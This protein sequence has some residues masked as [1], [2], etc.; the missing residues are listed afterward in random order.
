LCASPLPARAAG[1]P[2]PSWNDGAAK[3][4]ILEFVRATTTQGSPD[5]VASGERIAAFDQDGTLWV[6][7]PMYTQLLYCLDR[8]PMVVKTK[9]ELAKVEPFKTVL[10]GNREA[11]AKFSKD[12]LLK[13][14]AATLTGMTVEQF[15]KEAEDWLAKAVDPRWKRP[16]TALIYQ[17]MVE[18]MQYLR[19]NG[20]RTYIV[21]GGGQDFVRVYAG[22]VYGIPP[23]QV[24]GT[25]GE[26]K[27][28]YDKT[29]KP[30]LTKMP[31]LLLDNDKAGKPEGIHLMIGQR[32]R[33]AFGNS[34]GDREMLEY[35]GAGPGHPL[36]MLVH[37]DDAEREYAYGPNS[38]VGTF[39]DALMTEAKQRGW[40]VIS[41]KNDWKRIFAFEDDHR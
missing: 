38:K 19:D 28:G 7:Q 11:M 40:P 36:M 21:T 27:F 33:A 15:A 37:H 1:D 18:L 4:A 23:E 39:T 25:A 32:P 9:P 24:V 8:V 29:G 20:Y 26:T 10:S 41:M 17:P 35:T 14:V 2:L 34:I 22:R 16:Y 3:T 31:K 30:E 13:I 12:D 6:E 5:F